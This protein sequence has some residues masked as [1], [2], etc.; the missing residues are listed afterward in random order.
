MR[1]A[2]RGNWEVEEAGWCPG[3]AVTVRTDVLGAT[4][5]GNT[6]SVEYDYQDWISDGGTASGQNGAFYATSCFVIVKSNEPIAAATV[7]D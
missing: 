2:Q 5:G 6:L 1:K 3:M 7:A 4:D